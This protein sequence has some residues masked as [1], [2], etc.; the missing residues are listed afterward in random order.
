[1]LHLLAFT[2]IIS[3]PL[4]PPLPRVDP[5]QDEAP[6]EAS[7]T[8]SG[9]VDLGYTTTGGN[10]DVTTLTSSFDAT[11]ETER[12]RLRLRF[13]HNST[14][15]N[16]TATQRQTGSS[17]QYDYFVSERWYALLTGSAD[18]D[19]NAALELGTT[20]GAGAGYKLWFEEESEAMSRLDLEA[21]MSYFAEDFETDGDQ[22]YLT[23]RL[24]AHLAY[25]FSGSVGLE[26]DFELFAPSLED[27]ND[28]NA[29]WDTRLRSN[30]GERMFTQLQ[31]V[32]DFDSTPA[33]DSA[34]AELEELDTRIVL[35]LGW[36][37]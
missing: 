32:L 2:S 26:S 14:E 6:V 10:T 15:E 21:G 22:E 31:L 28:Y 30:L 29:K 9:A 36:S 1:V 7:T 33:Q 16:G 27:S 5:A 18:Q 4:A 23:A 11:R 17:L 34:G 20:Y 37:F 8:W 19:R 24:A 12:D 25:D 13:F 35:S 3:S